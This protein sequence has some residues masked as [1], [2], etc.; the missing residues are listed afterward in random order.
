MVKDNE[1]MEKIK[2]AMTTL[3]PLIDI[4]DPEKCKATVD[5]LYPMIIRLLSEDGS[6]EQI[7]QELGS[8]VSTM[9]LSINP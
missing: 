9:L 2:D 3:C 6:P 5:R 7:C 4:V 8:C 1:D